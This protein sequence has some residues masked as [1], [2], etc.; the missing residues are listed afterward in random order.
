V[1]QYN[2]IGTTISTGSREN[3]NIKRQEMNDSK[4]EELYGK[5]IQFT[6]IMLEEYDSLEIAGIMVAQ[7]LSIYRTAMTEQEYNQMVDNISD[8]RDLVH[9]F[10]GPDLQ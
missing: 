8:S 5:Y 2:N 3:T 10:H 6:E 1:L 7:A 9:T 4:I